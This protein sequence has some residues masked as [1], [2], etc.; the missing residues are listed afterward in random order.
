M[1]ILQLNIKFFPVIF[2]LP[3]LLVLGCADVP[4]NNP[5]DKGGDSYDSV[6]SDNRI[7]SFS[8]INP[9]VT[10][11]INETD[12]TIVVPV[13][14]GT[15]VEN[16]AAEFATNA[17]SVTIYGREQRSGITVN[18]FSKPVYYG[19]TA[20]DGSYREYIVSVETVMITSFSLSDPD[21]SWVENVGGNIDY[22]ANTITVNIPYYMDKNK[23]VASFDAVGD[24]YVGS[25]IQTSGTTANDFTGMVTY[26]VADENGITQDYT[27][28][29]NRKEGM[30]EHFAGSTGGYG[31][32]DGTGSAAS[33]TWPYGMVYVLDYC[34]ITDN[35]SHTIRKI[36]IYNA[37][38]TT[39]AGS[40]NMSGSADGTGGN[41]RFNSPAGITSDGTNLYVCDTG[42]QTIRKVVIATGAVTTLAG[43]PGQWGFNDAT[44]S[45]ARFNS[46]VGVTTD[47]TNLY[48][49]DQMNC[50]IRKVVISSGVVSTFAGSGTSSV[51]NGT[52]TGAGF[53]Y[54]TD[55][56]TD[57]TFL[58]ATDASYIRRISLPGAAVD[59]YITVAGCD[60]LTSIATDRVRLYVS[61]Y[62]SGEKIFQVPVGGGTPTILAGSTQGYADGMGLAAK[63]FAPSGM[64][65]DGTNLFVADK[66]NGVIRKISLLNRVVG[67]FAGSVNTA[68]SVDGTG[69]D[70]R[71]SSPRSFAVIGGYLYAA[72]G[73]PYIRKIDI[74]TGAVTTLNTIP[75]FT[76]DSLATDGTYLYASDSTYGELYKIDVSGETAVYTVMVNDLNSTGI[77]V[78]GSFLYAADVNNRRIRKIEL[79]TP[80][81][82]TAF[83][84]GPDSFRPVYLTSDG[85]SLY[86][87]DCDTNYK[88]YRIPVSTGE[89]TDF[90]GSGSAGHSDGTGSSAGFYRPRGLTTDGKNIYV[91]DC[92]NNLI[93]RIRISTGEV[94]TVAGRA[95]IAGNAAGSGSSALF[96]SP[97]GVVFCQS[98]KK[99]YVA[100]YGNNS[101]KVI[102]P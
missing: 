101:V 81:T 67:T 78:C 24:I 39:L 84:T 60:A 38:V 90:A 52:G 76:P 25:T 59:N 53:N 61:G 51:V 80:Y 50:R 83:V 5:A 2:L 37:E 40:P 70:A 99:L 73:N 100:D 14:Y 89:I 48:V 79:V 45:D 74:S 20:R 42:N 93:R 21:L 1:K 82:V 12:S 23:L 6:Y 65:T 11:V 85:T 13:L 86:A 31:S 57:G 94:T 71:L 43:S 102:N 91:A 92:D 54:L 9:A 55:I 62:V 88:I 87:S 36:G 96:N 4:R 8:F 95:L 64:T 49:A 16:L 15:D 7:T 41:A 10:G 75:Y 34:Y 27:V 66:I 46:P 26:K 44:G 35:I 77:T 32:S 33:F 30:T 47:G 98:N 17:G 3:A 19:V 18:D 63:F 68:G 97:F 56:T 72:G 58:Y 22:T 29:V 69:T 28:I